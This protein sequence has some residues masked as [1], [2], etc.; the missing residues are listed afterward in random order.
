MDGIFKAQK[1][2]I[3]IATTNIPWDL[4]VAMLRPGRFGL[5]KHVPAPDPNARRDLIQNRIAD[6][7]LDEKISLDELVAWSQD[8][9]VSEILDYL[10]AIPKPIMAIFRIYR[11]ADLNPKT[12]R[13]VV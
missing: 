7:R 2:T 9:T 6:M 1:R 3:H 12:T 8:N 10:E 13:L 5:V 11:Y 4:E